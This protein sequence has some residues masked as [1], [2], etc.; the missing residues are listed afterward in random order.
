MLDKTRL[1]WDP[2]QRKRVMITYKRLNIVDDYNF[3]MNSVDLADKA[4][5]LYRPD[6]YLRFKKWWWSIFMWVIGTAATNAYVLYAAQ[7]RKAGKEPCE[8]KVFRSRLAEQLCGI[9]QE[10]PGVA[11]AAAGGTRKRARRVDAEWRDK[12]AG[13][14]EGS[15]VL[16]VMQDSR[17]D[18]QLCKAETGRCV[19]A[20]LSCRTCEVKFCLGTCWETWHA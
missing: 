18:C 19:K 15:H 12:F 10:A 1:V 13:R 7:C 20:R 16:H 6:T 11:V 4:R 9:Q 17:T 14:T 3:G 2:A 5:M 8:H